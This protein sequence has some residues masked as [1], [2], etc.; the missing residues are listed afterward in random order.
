MDFK[1]FLLN[2]DKYYLGQRT[3]DILSAVQSL[4]DDAPNMGNRVL[5][6]S[7]QEI[8]NQIRKILHGSW[9][10]SDL[11]YLKKLQ[12]IGVAIAKGI[13]VKSD[14]KELVASASQELEDLVNKMD[15]PINTV[16]S[17]EEEEGEDEEEQPL[18]QGSQIN[19]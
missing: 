16:G 13:D 2:E 17:N 8:V 14:L 7:L 12:K 11:K 19:A 3:G 4:H 1:S 9:E 6:R 10:E 18:E 5:T 15:V